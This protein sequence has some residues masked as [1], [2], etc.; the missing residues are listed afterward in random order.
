ME[1]STNEL[2]PFTPFSMS[3]WNSNKNGGNAGAKE[4]ASAQVQQVK[5]SIFGYLFITAKLLQLFSGEMIKFF[6]VLEEAGLIK[7][8]LLKGPKK[9]AKV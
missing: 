6:E 2:N 5:K 9:I 7:D 1:D 4:P 8:E 3:N